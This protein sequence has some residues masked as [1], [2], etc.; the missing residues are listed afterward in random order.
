MRETFSSIVILLS[1]LNITAFLYPHTFH[2]LEDATLPS[3]TSCNPIYSE[4]LIKKTASNP[5]GESRCEIPKRILFSHI[6]VYAFVISSV[7]RPNSF[8]PLKPR[9]PELIKLF[10]EYSSQANPAISRSNIRSHLKKLHGCD[11]E[12]GVSRS[13]KGKLNK[14]QET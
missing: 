11:D 12:I 10:L 7:D 6:R 14:A 5:M 9:R 1:R 4:E 3:F 8:H 13:L 2:F